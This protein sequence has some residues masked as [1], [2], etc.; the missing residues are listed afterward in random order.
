[1]EYITMTIDYI[2]IVLFILGF[3]GNLLGLI[4]FSSRRFRC[5]STYVILALTSFTINLVCIVRYSLLLHSTAR[6]WLTKN[7][8][9]IYWL[10]CKLF[11][12]TTSFRVLSAWVTV[13][14]VIER[15]IY[16]LSR[17]NVL[18][19]RREKFRILENY[20]YVCMICI[21][22]IM[23]MTVSG[24]IT[25]FYAPIL[26]SFDPTNSTTK[27]TFDA[28]HTP[29]KWQTYFTGVSFGFNYHTIR[30]LFSEIIPSILVGLFNIGIII[31]IL[32]TTAHVR[33]RQEYHHN[34]M[35][36]SLV[37]GTTSKLSPSNIYDSNQQRRP[38]M[39]R[40][41]FKN[42]TATTTPITNAP[43]GKM[44]WMNIILILHSILFFLSFSA[45]SLV[46]LWTSS[47]ELAYATSIIILASCSLNFY[48]YCLSGKHFRT[49]LK[50]IA[51][52]YLRNLH[53]RI[54][55]HCYKHHHRRHSIIHNG[56]EQLY[57][58]L[59]IKQDQNII[60]LRQY[61]TIEHNR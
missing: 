10:A 8:V 9:D 25:F 13:F 48:V 32:L 5:C 35:S 6:L 45:S 39:R 1:M 55:R 41:S 27:C 58:E 18:F 38:S 36:M 28:N 22:L 57:Q 7:V 15:F 29:I 20:K 43:F 52:R 54:L 31:C 56:K 34:N 26:D 33:R 24:P 11:R 4:V 14:W 21:S 51:K 37:T 40:C 49:E 19:N 42:P 12:L 50:R 47:I 60:Q 61:Q 30:F 17:L 3:I 59:P 2:C 16:V 23:V 44:S 46:H 53:K